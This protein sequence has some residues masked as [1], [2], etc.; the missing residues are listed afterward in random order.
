MQ[1]DVLGPSLNPGIY[2]YFFHISHGLNTVMLR[3]DK[4][5][6]EV[7]GSRR[8]LDASVAPLSFATLYN[9]YCSPKSCQTTFG[10]ETFSYHQSPSQFSETYRILTFPGDRKDTGGWSVTDGDMLA[11][12]E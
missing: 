10:L 9:S 5:P 3:H 1:V 6:A 11:R 8:G 12:Q 4:Q 7:L 2:I